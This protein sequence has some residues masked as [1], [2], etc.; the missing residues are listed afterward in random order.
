MAQ[1]LRAAGL[2]GSSFPILSRLGT[3]GGVSAV[4]LE[5]QKAMLERKGSNTCPAWS[6]SSSVCGAF[7]TGT[8]EAVGNKTRP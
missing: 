2:C 4:A 8:T 6:I 3:D 7:V 1:R 5:L